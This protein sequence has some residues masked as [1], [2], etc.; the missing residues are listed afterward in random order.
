[1]STHVELPFWAAAVLLAFAAW[2]LIEHL[3]L[4]ALRWMVTQPANQA[5][6]SPADRPEGAAGR[7]K[8]FRSGEDSDRYGFEAR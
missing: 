2:A 6:P 7:R 4:P 8:I 1:M 5:H 3:L